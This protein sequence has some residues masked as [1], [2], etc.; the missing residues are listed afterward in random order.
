MELPCRMG[1][2]D[3]IL[4]SSNEEKINI[5]RKICPLPYIYLFIFKQVIPNNNNKINVLT[6]LI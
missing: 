4:W 3:K 2:W 5:L 6:N 1:R